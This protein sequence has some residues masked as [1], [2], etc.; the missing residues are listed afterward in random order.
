AV[1]HANPSRASTGTRA[2]TR[3]PLHSGHHHHHHHHHHHVVMKHQEGKAGDTVAG[4]AA[5]DAEAGEKLQAVSETATGTAGPTGPT[6]SDRLR[7]RVAFW[8]LGLCNNYGYV[9]MISAAYDILGKNFGLEEAKQI[10]GPRQC[11][12][13]STGAILLADILPSLI[14][15]ALSPF[16]PL[17]INLRLSLVVACNLAGFTFV[18]LAAELWVA[19]L[20]VAVMSAAQGL[21]EASL[22]A[23]TAFFKDKSIIALWSSGTGAAGVLGS[24]SYLGLSTILSPRDSILFMNLAPAATMLAFWGLL[25]RPRIDDNGPRHAGA[26]APEK[27]KDGVP[28]FSSTASFT[29]KLGDI[30]P[31]LKYICPLFAVYLFEYF[32]NQGLFELIQ[33][34]VEGLSPAQQYKMF[35]ALYQIGVFVSR[36]SGGYVPIERMWILAALQGVNVAYFMLEAVYQVSGSVWVVA[37][38]VV[39]EGL[40]G[41]AAYVRTFFCISSKVEPEKREFSMAMSSVADALGISAAGLLA[42]PAH[43]LLCALPSPGSTALPWLGQEFK[44]ENLELKSYCQKV[45][46]SEDM[47]N[48][49]TPKC[50]GNHSRK[51]SSQVGLTQR[52]STSLPQFKRTKTYIDDK[53]EYE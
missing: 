38:L 36:T 22:L 41:G 25:V 48:P 53:D 40:L 17:W 21:G 43:N 26:C 3:V 30:P 31:L 7:T 49:S 12:Y 14:V 39:W 23:Y 33:Y 10:P 4:A 11:N 46:E 20:G 28:M 1:V 32:I 18:A 5:G 50:D 8:V 51:K 47:N 44:K 15:K 2:G 45:Q 9:V 16:M 35:Q 29:D 42:I 27:V 6:A 37:V 13:L 52:L 34:D 24:V 19:L